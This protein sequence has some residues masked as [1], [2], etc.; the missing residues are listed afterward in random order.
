MSGALASPLHPFFFFTPI[1]V[2]PKFFLLFFHPNICHIYVPMSNYPQ[3]QFAGTN[4]HPFRVLSIPL[5]QTNPNPSR[6]HQNCLPKVVSLL[7]SV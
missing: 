1:F 7:S 3:K 2:F 4:P 5:Y 6:N